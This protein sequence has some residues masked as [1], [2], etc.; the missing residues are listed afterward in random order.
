MSS[1]IKVLGHPVHPMLVVFPVGLFATAVVFDI[2]SLVTNNPAFPGVAFYMITAGIIGG[3]LAA[4]FGL[5]DWLGLP[6]NSR[7]KKVGGWHGLGNLTIVILFA[8][9][10][11]LRR[12]D[13]NFVPSTPA[14]VLAFAGILLALVTAWIGGELVYRLGVGVD[15]GANVNAPTSLSNQPAGASRTPNQRSTAHTHR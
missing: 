11:L 6:A 5:L 8:T 1:G 4:I 9:S 2:L 12:G 15:V 13:P 14:L 7:A 10:W 3:L